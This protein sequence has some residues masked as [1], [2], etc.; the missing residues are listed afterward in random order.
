MHL[1]ATCH[2]VFVQC[3]LCVHLG[4]GETLST[5]KSNGYIF[6][7]RGFIGGGIAHPPS[8]SHPRCVL[9]RCRRVL[10]RGKD[11]HL[12]LPPEFPGGRGTGPL[13]H[14]AGLYLGGIRTGLLPHIN[15]DYLGRGGTGPPPHNVGKFFSD[16]VLTQMGRSGDTMVCGLAYVLH[17]G[18]TLQRYHAMGVQVVRGHY[19][20]G[21][22]T[23]GTLRRYLPSGS[24]CAR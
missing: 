21:L 7:C 3:W 4:W 13:P 15:G 16:A 18:A 11:W 20:T 24:V 12:S 1:D 6:M 19:R 9:Q 14:S 17:T 2:V 22:P 23:V 10:R 5:P 8:S